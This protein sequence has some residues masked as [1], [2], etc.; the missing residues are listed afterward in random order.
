MLHSS[1]PS[2]QQWRPTLSCSSNESHNL[3]FMPLAAPFLSSHPQILVDLRHAKKKRERKPFAA[4][5]AHE[6]QRQS[7]TVPHDW[8]YKSDGSNYPLASGGHEQ[9]S[10][11]IFNFNV[12]QPF[13]TQMGGELCVRRKL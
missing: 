7:F 1:E 11:L 8:Q 3:L 9:V 10:H 13:Y 4:F 2:P 12:F 5:P 6:G